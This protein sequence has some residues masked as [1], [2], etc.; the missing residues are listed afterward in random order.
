MN[1]YQDIFFRSMDI[2]R[3]RKTIERLYELRKSQHWSLEKI[4]ESQL[5]KLNILLSQAINNSDYYKE[6][7]KHISLPLKSLN[8]LNK[9]PILTKD[10]IRSN[11]E[12]IKCKN[13]PDKRFFAARTG[14]STGVPMIY[15]WD[16]QGMDANRASV[17]R[18]AEWANTKLG[19]RTIQMSGSHF[20]YTQ[21]QNLK[22]KIVYFLQRF[23]D[24]NIAYLT[25]E[26]L[27]K[28]YQELLQYK[29]TSI[30]GYAGG[31]NA[32]A[33]YIDKKH[34]D[35]KFPFIKA[36]M[37][38]SETLRPEQR[39]IINKVF[40]ENKVYDQYGS[41][42]LYIASECSEHDG[43]HI[44]ADVLIAEIVDANGNSVKPG[45]LG[46]VI[47]TDLTNHAFPF[48][49][50]EIGDLGTMDEAKTCGCGMA[51]PKLKSIQGR[52]ADVIILKDRLLTAP[53]F[54]LIFSDKQG[55][56]AYQVRQYKI[57]EIEVIM[58]PDEHYNDEFENYVRTSIE[59][60]LENQATLKITL[61]DEIE[62]PESGKRRYII[63]NISKDHFTAI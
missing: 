41:R 61:A 31:I 60:M 59:S 1:F 29:P 46:R 26:R 6:K 55:V 48:I 44:H 36:I 23:R 43:Y 39:E 54:T 49:R 45:E 19:E 57:D 13:I 35:T 9:I 42:E 33:E 2:L 18:S 21:A 38:S 37:T 8:D 12:E 15:F 52:I 63:S 22:N 32:F 58:V 17:Y 47:L 24:F 3:G 25:E 53:N 14:G 56:Q 27:E 62:L 50:Y 16:T 4:Q 10:D 40:G 30:W 11:V 20:D 7:L 51:L 5:K 34:P 28:Y